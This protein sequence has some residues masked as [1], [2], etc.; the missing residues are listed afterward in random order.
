MEV[1][2]DLFLNVICHLNTLVNFLYVSTI[3]TG[4][5]RKNTNDVIRKSST[6]GNGHC[7]KDEIVYILQHTGEVAAAFP[8]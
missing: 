7:Y 2:T 1:I 8:V 5:Y 6:Q 4:P 3:L